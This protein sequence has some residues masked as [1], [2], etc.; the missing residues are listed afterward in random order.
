MYDFTY[1]AVAGLPLVSYIH[2]EK[3]DGA[4]SHEVGHRVPPLHRAVGRRREKHVHEA[5]DGQRGEKIKT[6]G[7]RLHMQRNSTHSCICI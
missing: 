5:A 6:D 1:N 7:R 4:G 3:R 2:E